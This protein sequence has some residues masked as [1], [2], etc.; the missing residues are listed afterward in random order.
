MGLGGPGRVRHRARGQDWHEAPHVSL[1]E[2]LALASDALRIRLDEV[3]EQFEPHAAEVRKQHADRVLEPGTIDGFT[4][5]CRGVARGTALIELEWIGLVGVDPDDPDLADPHRVV[6]S[7]GKLECRV[8]GDAVH[9]PYPA[10]AARAI[11]AIAPLRTLPPGLYS[12]AQ[13][14]IAV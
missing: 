6:I 9:D 5:T 12:P 14:P 11:N 7:A 2:S 10:T 3:E 1:A 4:L 8:S 13:L